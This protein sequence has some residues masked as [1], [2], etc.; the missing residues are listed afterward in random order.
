MLAAVAVIIVGAG[1]A[2]ALN[3]VGKTDATVRPLA[4]EIPRPERP[5]AASDGSATPDTTW[6][7]S[8]TTSSV[9]VEVPNVVGK[10]ITAAETLIQAAGFKTQTRVADKATPG[11]A[12][13]TVVSQWPNAGLRLQPGKRVVITYQP[14]ASAITNA[15]QPVVVIDPGHQAKANLGLEPI[16]PGSKQMKTMVAGGAT[17]V[18]T[19]I[20]EYKQALAI[21]LKLR[22][23]LQAEGVKVVM[24]RVTNDV[25]I[26]NAQ[27]AKIGN[28]AKADLVV[29]VHLDS[30]TNSSVHGISALYPAGNSW[31][32]PIEASSKKAA[33]YV[34]D[35]VTGATGATKRGLFGRSDMTGFNW[36][37][38]PTII[39]E[40]GFMSNADED[41]RCASPAYQGK[42]AAGICT[43]VLKYFG[44]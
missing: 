20:P 3:S 9:E 36:S 7:A 31:C 26:T 39:V 25:N 6:A 18:S 21:S 23:E 41:R 37:T 14:Q 43:G 30:A 11:V 28:D 34:E 16:G 40:C 44:R 2:F 13:D 19:G 17:G 10:S 1:V 5:I 24:V 12:P 15:N 8:A 35:A 33:G 42:I 22:D 38:R 32:A 29:R 27:R 4:S